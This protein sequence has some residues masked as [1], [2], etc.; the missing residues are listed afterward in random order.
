MIPIGQSARFV[1]RGEG[2]R[3]RGAGD[4]DEERHEASGM[5]DGAYVWRV[6]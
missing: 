6:R 5:G 1:E 4:R 2:R 3:G